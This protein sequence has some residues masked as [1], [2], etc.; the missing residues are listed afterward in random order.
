V[1]WRVVV[2]GPTPE[3]TR[4]VAPPQ[5]SEA[6]AHDRAESARKGARDAYSAAQSRFVATPVYDRYRLQPGARFAGPAIVEERESTVVVPDGATVTV[7]G[8]RNLVV[9]LPVKPA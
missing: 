6:A 3:L 9:E 8:Y 1:S 7:D 4:T 5:V 2:H